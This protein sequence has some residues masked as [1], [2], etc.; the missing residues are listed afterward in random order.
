MTGIMI[1]VAII[2]AGAGITVSASILVA[3]LRNT[4]RSPL[5]TIYQ[6]MEDP[7]QGQFL[8]KIVGYSALIS[9]GLGTVWPLSLAVMAAMFLKPDGNLDAFLV[10][11]AY[12]KNQVPAAT[13]TPT[14]AK[15]S[16]TKVTG[17]GPLRARG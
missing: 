5:T 9:I 6:A 14:E 2:Y 1:G 11:Y 16:V 15:G 3:N 13:E 4:K 17:R 12:L 10:P 8:A 7:P